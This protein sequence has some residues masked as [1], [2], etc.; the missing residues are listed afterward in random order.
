MGK[1]C[2]FELLLSWFVVVFKLTW[3]IFFLVSEGVHEQICGGLMLLMVG[4]G[5]PTILCKHGKLVINP[6]SFLVSSWSE[7]F[8]NLT[9]LQMVLSSLIHSAVVIFDGFAMTFSCW[10]TLCRF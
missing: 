9:G 5:V 1:L 10:W 2:G 4:M 6:L 7:L 3:R 8:L